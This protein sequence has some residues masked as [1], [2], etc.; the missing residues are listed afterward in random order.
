MDVKYIGGDEPWTLP[1]GDHYN[2]PIETFKSSSTS[3]SELESIARRH[4]FEP[5]YSAN[6]KQSQPRFP[7]ANDNLQWMNTGI[8][9]TDK[10][11]ESD[12]TGIHHTDFSDNHGHT[13]CYLCSINAH[14]HERSK[15]RAE[16]Q[17]RKLIPY[18]NPKALKARSASFNRPASSLSTTNST[19]YR[20]I[21]RTAKDK[22]SGTRA[23]VFLYMYGT[24]QDWTSINLRAGTNQ[25]VDGFPAGSVRTFCLKGPDIGEL[26]RL[27]VNLVG[28]R[29]SKEWFL[30]E[31]EITNLNTSKTW[32]CEFNCW[33]PKTNDQ[34][35]H[36]HVKPSSE[37]NLKNLCVYVLQVRTGGKQFAGTDSLIQVMIKG[38]DS[39]TRQLSL[40]SD[41]SNLFEQNQ[42]D[43]FAIVGWDLGDLLELTVTSDRTHMASDWDLKEMN[44]W[45]ILP[46]N[47]SKQVLV[48]FPFNQW[49]GK[50]KS[51]LTAKRETY[52][53][54]DH[55]P[56]GP[57]CYHIAI[58]TGDVRGAGT[59][60]NVYIIIYGESGRSTTHLL[61]NIG[62]ND[63]ERNTTSE[64]TVMDIDVGNINAIKIWHDNSKPGAAWFLDTVIVRKKHSVCRSITNIFI[65]R[66]T[67]ISKALYNQACEQLKRSH[68]IQFS[69]SKDKDH[70]SLDGSL[71]RKSTLAKKVTWDEESIG[72]QDERH[73]NDLLRSKSKQAIIDQKRQKSPVPQ[74][75]EA[76]HFDHK[77]TWISSHNYRDNKWRIKSIEEANP[78]KLDKSTQSLLLSDRLTSDNKIKTTV[79]SR[80]DDIYEFQA[81]C[82]LAKDK[83]DGQLEVT[84]K[85]KASQLSSHSS[86]ETKFKSSF[87]THHDDRHTKRSSPSERDIP[88]RSPR[89]I[90]PSDRYPRET[91]KPPVSE[92]RESHRTSDLL[93]QLKESSLDKNRRPASPSQSPKHPRDHSERIVPSASERDLLAKLTDS[94]PRHPPSAVKSLIDTYSSDLYKQSGRSPR[95][96]LDRSSP[97]TS[98]RDVPPRTPLGPSFGSKS[99]VRS[100]IETSTHRPNSN[101]IYGSAYGTMPTDKF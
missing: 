23:Q 69:S 41:A 79:N 84:L 80:D 66:V 11:I 82:W 14:Q 38:T 57:T 15:P 28:A 30:K 33:L 22:D 56:R 37:L 89:S 54:V 87:D 8:L 21:V 19:P 16:S 62:K 9:F 91:G 47:E 70:Y 4:G 3:P 71:S 97:L 46:D 24:D 17:R 75:A 81:N 27:N 10:T 48:Y 1:F 60:A 55:H 5:L 73:S 96:N 42:L 26:R 65:Q 68:K 99:G 86:N 51:T 36:S 44:I 32:L 58:K 64:F 72:S 6:E 52:R 83:S 12:M 85:P 88:L 59:D 39:Q 74:Q 61:D 101:S 95:S 18:D 25:T 93:S 63:F 98:G 53:S 49:I 31:I 100:L 40:T 2:A 29:S 92:A 43:T 90:T 76:G 7:F 34:E 77:A 67:Q 45:K 78:L 50:K 13:F 94:S 35:P 20:F